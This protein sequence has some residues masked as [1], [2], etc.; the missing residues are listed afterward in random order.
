MVM[1]PN[2]MDD[3]VDDVDD[4]DG[5]NDDDDDDD[6]DNDDDDDSDDD[7]DYYDE[8]GDDDENGNVEGVVSIGHDITYIKQSEEQ[9]Q[10]LKTAIN[11]TESD[12]VN[13]NLYFNSDS[14]N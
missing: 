9:L 14:N 5:G 7:D 4:D 3:D 1:M 11:N 8:E 10:L 2:D 13:Y 12:T 6:D